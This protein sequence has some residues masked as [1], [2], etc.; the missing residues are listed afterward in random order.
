MLVRGVGA[1]DL[2]RALNSA[3]QDAI[4]VPHEP[5]IYLEVDLQPDKD[6]S[7]LKTQALPSRPSN[8][9][10]PILRL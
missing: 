4:G 5:K 2:E 8:A 10:H 9:R 3:V 7:R 1:F 6:T